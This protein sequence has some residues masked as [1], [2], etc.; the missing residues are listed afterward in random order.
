MREKDDPFAVA[1]DP[2]V[3]VDRAGGCLGLEVW[4]GVAE[5]EAA[6]YLSVYMRRMMHDVRWAGRTHG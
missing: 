6:V 2:L 5:A 4:G 3:E 1:V